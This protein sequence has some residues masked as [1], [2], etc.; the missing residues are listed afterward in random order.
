MDLSPI[1]SPDEIELHRLTQWI[2]VT[3]SQRALPWLP[4]GTAFVF[5]AFWHLAPHQ[6]LTFWVAAIIIG[7]FVRWAICTRILN[8]LPQASVEELWRNER[9]LLASGVLN[10]LLVGS[11]FW[12]LGR[13]DEFIHTALL[14]CVMYAVGILVNNSVHMR[15][16]VPIVLSVMLPGIIYFSGVGD[17]TSQSTALAMGVVTLVL[18]QLGREDSRLF[19]I[20]VRTRLENVSLVRRLEDEKQAVEAALNERNQLLRAASHDLRGRLSTLNL[21]LANLDHSVRGETARTRLDR[22]TAAAQGLDRLLD[23]LLN[24]SALDGRRS[25][26]A[27]HPFRLDALLDRIA[28]AYRPKANLKGIELRLASTPC[29][30]LSNEAQVERVL[31]NL[32]SNAIKY[33]AFGKV[34]MRA[35]IEGTAVRVSVEDTG[36][37][38]PATDHERV[39]DDFVRLKNQQ[40]D[41]E[42]GVGLGLAIVRRIDRALGLGLT[43]QSAPGRG[44]RFAFTLPRHEKEIDREPLAATPLPAQRRFSLHVCVIED[45]PNI[46]LGLRDLLDG[47][48]CL[49]QLALT[50]SDLQTVLASPEDLPDLFLCDDML[51]GPDTGLD[52]CRWLSRFV[53]QSRIVMMTGNLDSTRTDEIVGAGFRLLTKPLSER[54]LVELLGQTEDRLLDGDGDTATDQSAD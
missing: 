4:V 1:R 45:D 19:N 3:Q 37:G 2:R 33:T 27:R 15:S 30:V 50:R 43:L 13:D 41:T 34:T 29:T 47:M 20:A 44:S 24:V 5:W 31:E 18:I 22:T 11:G 12:W 7:A 21:H 46:R 23:A 16:Y 28:T 36:V 32:V 54:A 53:P 39:F 51:G 35:R 42:S 8:T 6:P 38:I 52:L 49:V 10:G 40:S 14:F 48:G 17:T 25:E 26:I 9:W